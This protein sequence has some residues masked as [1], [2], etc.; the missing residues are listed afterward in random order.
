[1][2]WLFHQILIS[3]VVNCSVFKYLYVREC[4]SSFDISELNDKTDSTSIIELCFLQKPAEMWFKYGSY[5]SGIYIYT[6]MGKDEINRFL[7]S[8]AIRYLYRNGT[9]L[10]HSAGKVYS[11]HE[12]QRDISTAA[13]KQ[14][15]KSA[16]LQNALQNWK[17]LLYFATIEITNIVRYTNGIY[18]IICCWVVQNLSVRT[19]FETHRG[20]VTN[21]IS[22]GGDTN[23][24]YIYKVPENLKLWS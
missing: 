11:L 22:L 23:M 4:K 6:W 7:E 5:A 19:G 15:R 24:R 18:S 14:K 13:S 12:N 20:F 21:S 16:N 3:W 8:S 17:Y 10:A 2:S 1:M 9:T